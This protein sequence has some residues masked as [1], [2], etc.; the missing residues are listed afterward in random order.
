VA[1]IACVAACLVFAGLAALALQSRAGALSAAR[2]HAAQLVRLQQI[3]SHLVEADSQFTNGYLT[4]GQDSTAQLNGYDQAMAEAS[5]LVTVA[6]QAEPDDADELSLVNDALSQYT[7]RVAAARANNKQG[8]QVGVGYLRQA[9]TL[10]RSPSSSVNLLP[11]LNRLISD[12]AARVDDSFAAAGRAA[13]LL[14]AAGVLGLG[15]LAT[16]QFWL[17]RRS[18]RF[19]NLPLLAATVAVLVGLVAGAVVMMTA[20]SRAD[21]VRDNSYAATR[22]LANARIAAYVGKSHQS[23][24]LIYIG[25]GGDYPTSQKDYQGQVADAKAALGRA[26]GAG[27]GA[28]VGS[29]DLTRWIAASDELTTAAQTDWISAAAKATSTAPG[30]VNTLFA[31]FDQ[32]TRPALDTQAT[33]VRDGLNGTQGALTT[34][35]WLVLLLG[36]AAAGATWL[37]ISLRLEEYR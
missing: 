8:Y 25:T 29:T 3:A 18:H 6:A 14:A 16:V 23:I 36:V 30:T 31:A 17:A 21:Q 11:T 5:R 22:A 19:L 7:A 4:F 27:A 37:G 13:W 24:T 35:G 26:A 34:I 9:S 33:A 10:L 28:E 12:N 1:G 15:T 2:D 32:G 20:Q